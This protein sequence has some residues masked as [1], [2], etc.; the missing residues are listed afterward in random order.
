MVEKVIG[1]TW[2]PIK[3]RA[4]MYKTVVHVILL[5]GIES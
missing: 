5:Y 1:K 3:A 2:T 4:M